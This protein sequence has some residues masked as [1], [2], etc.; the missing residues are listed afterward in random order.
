MQYKNLLVALLICLSTHAMAQDIMVGHFSAADLSSWEEKE[1]VGRTQYSLAQLGENTVLQAS[2]N[3]SASAF[4]RSAKIDLSKTPYLHWSWQVEN[5]YTDTDANTKAGDDYPARI[6]VVVEG[7]WPWNTLALNYVFANNN[8]PVASSWANPF[9][10]NAHMIVVDSD[11]DHLHKMRSYRVDVRADFKRYFNEDVDSIDGIAIMSDSD[12]SKQS[13]K[14][15]F[16][17]IYFSQE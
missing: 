1:F 10:S 3:A 16:G 12:N 15:Y 2:S 14:A 8:E 9:T 5:I 4:Y 6:Y 17:D 7:F 13:S 11:P